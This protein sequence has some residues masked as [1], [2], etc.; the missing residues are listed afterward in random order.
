MLHDPAIA[1]RTELTK[2]D[3]MAGSQQQTT[4]NHFHEKLLKLEALM[5]TAHGKALA[6]KR[7][8]LLEQFLTEFYD[9]W[10]AADADGVIDRL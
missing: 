6:R 4:V 10:D 3:Y 2:Q 1:P 5:H 9:E 8:A 7:T